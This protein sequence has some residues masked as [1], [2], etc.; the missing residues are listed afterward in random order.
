MLPWWAED[1]LFAPLFKRQKSV[2]RRSITSNAGKALAVYNDGTTKTIADEGTMESSTNAADLT[3]V[4]EGRALRS[5]VDGDE[6]KRGL[7]G[8]VGMRSRRHTP[9]DEKPV[10]APR[11]PARV[12]PKV[13]TIIAILFVLPFFSAYYLI[14][15]FQISHIYISVKL[16]L[17]L[18]M[19]ERSSS[20]SQLEVYF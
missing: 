18:L 10:A 20:G 7:F 13:M 12:E 5:T 9:K 1:A 11:S 15:F 2:S 14:L 4:E 19:S 6:T 16:S 17:F 3:A 8:V